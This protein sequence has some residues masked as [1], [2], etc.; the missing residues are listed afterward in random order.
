MR[1]SWQGFDGGAEAR[2]ALDAFF[3]DVTRRARPVDD[4]RDAAHEPPRPA[5][6]AVRP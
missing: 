3:A 6:T 2:T 4:T 5:R 1:L